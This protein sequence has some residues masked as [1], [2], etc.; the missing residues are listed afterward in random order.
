MNNKKLKEYYKL[1][2]IH[3]KYLKNFTKLF[4]KIIENGNF[5]LGSELIKFEKNFS[6]FI[7]AKYCLGV[8]NGYDA[9]KLIL[10]SCD[11]GKGDEII[12]SS[13]TFIATWHSISS[14]GAI[15]VPIDS[16]YD[17]YN[18][19]TNLIESK[20]TKKTKAIVAV[21]LYGQPVE[22]NKI[23]SLCK[24]YNLFYFEDAAQA[25]GAKYRDKKVGNLGD[26][27]AFSFYPTKNIGALGDAG[28]VTTN[29]YKIYKKLVKLRNYGKFKKDDFELIGYNSRLDD[30]QA[31][32]LNFKLSKY[33][34]YLKLKKKII[35]YYSKELPNIKNEIE[36]PETISEIEHVWHHYV[37]KVKKRKKLMNFLNENGFKT[38]IH[39]RLPPHQT[40][41]YRYLK[42]KKTNLKVTEKLSKMILSLPTYDL[43]LAKKITA[44]IK[45]FYNE[46]I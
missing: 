7:G 15:P 12:V 11:I 17:T 6:N 23:K 41:A 33:N 35:I 10:L 27:A 42:I 3:L 13:H 8:A 26:A 43:F 30:I 9:L 14:I 46:N 45:L 25:H 19:N 29:N 31:S 40:K 2:F 38:M 44:K 5:I 36:L 32:F 34:S 20:I 16:N 24:K 4:V 1:D 21:H 28:A 18:L 37:V 39:Y 22:S